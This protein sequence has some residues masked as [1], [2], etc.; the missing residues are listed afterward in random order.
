MY[1][2]NDDIWDDDDIKIILYLSYY[3]YLDIIFD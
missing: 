1:V 2:M 3:K